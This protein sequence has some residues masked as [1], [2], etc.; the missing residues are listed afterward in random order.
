MSTENLNNKE[1]ILKLKD[2]V[3]KIDIG[4]VCS[5]LF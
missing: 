4:M 1:A 5:R 2:M 3:D